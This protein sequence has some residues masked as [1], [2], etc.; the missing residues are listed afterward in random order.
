MPRIQAWADWRFI[1][2]TLMDYDRW[3]K[4]VIANEGRQFDQN[5]FRAGHI[6]YLMDIV[7]MLY[8]QDR[9]REAM[10]W[11]DYLRKNYHL[12]QDQMT[13]DLREFVVNRINQDSLPTPEAA[14]EQMTAALTTHFARLANGDHR[15][16]ME[17]LN[18][19]RGVWDRWQK[20]AVRRLQEESRFPMIPPFEEFRAGLLAYFLVS[21]AAFGRD[22]DLVTRSTIYQQ[23]PDVVQRVVFFL[24]AGSGQDL[25]RLGYDPGTAGS[26]PAQCKAASLDFRKAFPQPPGMQEFLNSLGRRPGGGQAPP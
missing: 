7:Q 8:L 18:V 1:D 13:C 17:Y 9:P 12:S 19:A 5:T 14:S 4:L 23:Q 22:V 20:N 2:S 15:G 21:P 10:K 3:V 25:A 24:I 11:L 26:L 16:S 6:N